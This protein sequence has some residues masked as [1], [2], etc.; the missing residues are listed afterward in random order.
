MIFLYKDE[1]EEKICLLI[2]LIDMLEKVNN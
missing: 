1:K 2:C